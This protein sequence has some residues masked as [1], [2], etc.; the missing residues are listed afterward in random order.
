V[1]EDD[2]MTRCHVCDGLRARGLKVLEANCAD[3]AVAVLD[4]VRIDLLIIDIDLPGSRDGLDVARFVHA[5]LEP[6]QIILTSG[7]PDASHIP[8]LGDVGLLVKKPYLVE[9]LVEVVS[10]RLNW[11][12][13]SNM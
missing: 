10:R 2:V 1:V 12:S 5:R 7:A 3:D 13:A 6:T 8:D 11:P 4:R 9:Q